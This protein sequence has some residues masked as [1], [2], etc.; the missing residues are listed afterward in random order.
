[1]YSINHY[2]ILGAPIFFMKSILIVKTSSLGDIIQSFAA[3]E[4]LKNGDVEEVVII[5]RILK[6]PTRPSKTSPTSLPSDNN[7]SMILM[8]SPRSG[9][10]IASTKYPGCGPDAIPLSRGDKGKEL[11]PIV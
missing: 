10:I 5:N 2:L 3:L 9:L 1:M 7:S 8:A 6:W 11:Q 4:Y